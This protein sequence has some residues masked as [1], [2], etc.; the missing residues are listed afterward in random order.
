M[1]IKITRSTEF[2]KWFESLT[3]R[4]QVIID[5]RIARIEEFDHF[6]DCKYL[7]EGLAELRWKNGFRVYFLKLNGEIILLL[8]GGLKNAQSKDIKK[9]RILLQ[10]YAIT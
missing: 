10:K 1:G 7:G 2:I 6:G 9:A 5:A 8:I 3:I 4:D